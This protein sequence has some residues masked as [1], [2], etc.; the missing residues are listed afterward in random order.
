MVSRVRQ[1]RIDRERFVESLFSLANLERKTVAAFSAGDLPDGRAVL[2]ELDSM[3]AVVSAEP[4]LQGLRIG[5]KLRALYLSGGDLNALRRA[6]QMAMRD[7]RDLH[8]ESELPGPG[9]PGVTA[10]V[11]TDGQS[12]FDRFIDWLAE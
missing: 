11:A 8:Q 5:A 3:P 6:V 4:Q 9:W 2:S 10:A 1:K 7:H 12:G